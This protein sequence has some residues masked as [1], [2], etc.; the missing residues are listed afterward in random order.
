MTSSPTATT[1][2]AGA[3]M[4]M[5]IGSVI[6]YLVVVFLLSYLTIGSLMAAIG[7]AVNEM[8]EAQTMTLGLKNTNDTGTTPDSTLVHLRDIDLTTLGPNFGK[9]CYL[10]EMYVWDASLRYSFDNK[11][12]NVIL[13]HYGYQFLTFSAGGP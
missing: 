6:A 8:R 3:P 12:V 2:F 9:C 13:P 4:C 5:F 1:G 7:S 10:L 11:D